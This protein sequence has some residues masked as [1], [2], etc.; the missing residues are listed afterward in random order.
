MYKLIKNE[1]FERAKAQL[2][3]AELRPR[4]VEPVEAIL[5]GN[6]VYVQMPTGG[7]KSAVFMLPALCFAPWL[8]IVISPLLALQ[9]DQ[10]CSLRER[11]IAAEVLNS[12]L[13]GAEYQR[14][15][16]RVLDGKATLL[17]LAPE[18]LLSDRVCGVLRSVRI[19]QIVVDEA[20]VLA[21]DQHSFRAAYGQ[22]GAFI[23][24]LPERPIVSAFTATATKRDRKAIIKSLGMLRPVKF[25]FPMRRTNLEIT[26]KAVRARAKGK[27]R[28]DIR[29]GKLQLAQSYLNEWN[30]KGSVVIYCPTVKEV[31]ATCQWLRARGFRAG[32]YHGK[33]RPKKRAKA[34]AAFM[35]GEVPIMVATNAFG[36]GI[37]KPDVRLIIHMGLPLSMDGYVQEIGR[38]G[39]DGET[40]RCI[41]IYAANDF[42]ANKALLLHS[43]KKK[44]RGE[45]LARLNALAELVQ[46]GRCIWKEIEHYF[47]EKE[48]KK[49]GKC[50]NCNLI[51]L[52]KRKDSV[53][54]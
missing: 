45:V 15:L 16:D 14:V 52:N 23:A 53:V 21:H 30:G 5:R 32:K 22:V 38:A 49:C 28:D 33:M 20:H 39:R 44:R 25:I 37:D 48:G 29:R 8:T 27:K 12:D 34:Q 10:V 17:Y 3:F 2:G 36:L 46:S 18:Q 7:G 54:M 9:E 31:K 47:G 43:T 11:G 24:S 35:S 19:A 40:A 41:L 1:D 42:A 50:C 51:A 6:D 26:I 4:Q 13:S